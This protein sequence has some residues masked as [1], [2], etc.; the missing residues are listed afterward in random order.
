ME[1]HKLF[2]YVFLLGW[3]FLWFGFRAVREALDRKQRRRFREILHAER[4]ALLEQGLD[5]LLFEDENAALPA[6]EWES[7]T[8]RRPHRPALGVG[9][10]LGLAGMGMLIGFSLSDSELRSVAGVGCVPLGTG[11]GFLLYDLLTRHDR[12][13]SNR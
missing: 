9:L 1:Y 4:L 8:P 3:I 11:L 6:L 7:S 12:P 13:G 10:V 5:P 2:F